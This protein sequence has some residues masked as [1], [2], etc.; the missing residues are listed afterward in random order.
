MSSPGPESEG[1]AARLL[2][3]AGESE[4]RQ[5]LER[6]RGT[7]LNVFAERVCTAEALT[8]ALAH[9][10][11]LAVCGSEVTGLGFREVAPLLREKAPSLAFLVLT[12]RWEEEELSAALVAGAQGYLDMGRLAQVVLEVQREVRRAIERRQRLQAEERRQRKNEFLS[13]LNHD[14]RSPLNGIIGYCDLLILEEG[15]HLTQNGLHDL[16]MVKKNAQTLLSLINDVLALIKLEAGRTDVVNELVNFRELTEECVGAVRETLE[17]KEL[18]LTTHLA[19]QVYLLRTDELKL[20]QV[21]LN[22][23]GYSAQATASGRIALTARAEGQDAL[24]IVEDTGEGIP[25]DQLPFLFEDFC[26]AEDSRGR[27]AA[28]TS[29]GLVLAKE[30]TRVLGGSLSVQ[31]TLGQGTTFFVRLPC[32]VEDEAS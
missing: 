11:D 29:L 3:V 19:E 18:A 27:K 5:V 25:E 28:G 8:V 23:L 9:S 17:G 13:D 2:F 31:S 20:R 15:R 21:L 14:I 4:T 22:L 30:L 26:E 12:S 32:L 16:G 10:W 7:G 24:L 1:V 6:L